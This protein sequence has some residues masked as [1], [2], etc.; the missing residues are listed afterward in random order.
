MKYSD[1]KSTVVL[2]DLEENVCKCIGV[3]S[4]KTSIDDSI[5]ISRWFNWPIL[6]ALW[7]SFGKVSANNKVASDVNFW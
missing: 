2:E 5:F 7:S 6:Q 1:D 4:G 3:L